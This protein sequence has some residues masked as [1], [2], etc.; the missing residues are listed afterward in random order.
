MGNY[1]SDDTINAINNA[2]PANQLV[3][4]GTILDQALAGILPSGSI[5]TA[6]MADNAITTAKE[7]A[8]PFC[9]AGSLTAAAAATPVVLLADALVP[10]GKKVYVTNILL[11]VGGGTAWTDSSGT[12]VTVEDTAGADVVAYAKA[13]LTAN[14]VINDLGGANLTPGATT[15]SGAGLGA[16]KGLQIVADSDF[17]AGST[18][19]VVVSG[20]IK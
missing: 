6:E 18:I 17:D 16:G 12:K 13:G 4:L 15:L 19:S 1:L 14:V 5:S 3:G 2:S 8:T 10:A 20:V 7:V 9:V 11:K